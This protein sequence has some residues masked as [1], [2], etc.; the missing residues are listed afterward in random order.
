MTLNYIWWLGSSPG[1]LGNIDYNFNAITPRSTQTRSCSIY[2]NPIYWSNGPVFKI[3]FI[4]QE[5]LIPYNCKLFV[6]RTVNWKYSYFLRTIII[7]Y[8]KPYSY[9]QIKGQ[10]AV[11]YTDCISVEPPTTGVLD[12]SLNHPMASLQLWRFGECGV[13]LHCHCSYVHSDP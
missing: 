8:L 11:E 7:S 9:K 13:S 10:S 3:I 12:M 6:L 1:N 4:Q 5:Y 2:S